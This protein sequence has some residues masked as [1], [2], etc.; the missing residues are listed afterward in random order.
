MVL[1]LERM[2]K[3]MDELQT[4]GISL[5]GRL[6]LSDRAHIILPVHRVID[7]LRESSMGQE[8]IG[9]TKLGIGP[10]YQ[11]KMGRYGI[12]TI[13][14]KNKDVLK[15][16]IDFLYN[17]SLRDKRSGD[18]K[19]AGSAKDVFA[20]YLRI[21]SR[22][23]RYIVDTSDY[24]NREMKGG[25]RVLF[26]GAQGT[27]LDI[28]YGTYP[29]V[30]SSSSS[31][32]G[33]CAGLGISPKWVHGIV[34]VFKAYTTRV[35][36]GPFPTEEKGDVGEQIRKIG[37]EFG[38]TTGRP[39]RCGWFDAIAAKYSTRINNFDCI[40]M[41]LLDVL[42]S[43]KEIKICTKYRYDGNECDQFPSEPW[44]LDRVEPVY[45][46]MDGWEKP[47]SD[48][49]DLSDLPQNARRYLRRIAELTECEIGIVSVGPERNQSI[50][51]KESTFSK[52]L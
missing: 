40:A 38:T 42:C 39:R 48:I 36:S 8:R 33:I 22:L 19:S 13:D 7:E 31:A 29:Y 17:E 47:I 24:L 12:R 32:A 45:E 3:E 4:A 44:V 28:D 41:T 34:G 20:K 10:T 14:L 37:N 43:F 50:I 51:P 25:S 2:L 9:T 21:A 23:E 35:G 46:T 5:E 27:L 6:Y 15:Q 11:S 26:E 16:K 1:D 30:T 52:Y 18:W 49:R